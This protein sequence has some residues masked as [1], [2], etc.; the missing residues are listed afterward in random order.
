ML[1]LLL[2][3]DLLLLPELRLLDDGCQDPGVG[4]DHHDQGDEVDGDEEEH[5]DDADGDGR[6]E[7]EAV[8]VGVA[9]SLIYEPGGEAT[10]ERKKEGAMI[11]QR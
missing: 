2:I 7:D 8:D 1:Q 10:G 5:G 11:N 4:H 3:L 9:L 6:D